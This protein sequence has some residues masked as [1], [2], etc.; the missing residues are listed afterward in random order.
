M[1]C[2]IWN[3]YKYMAINIFTF[4]RFVVNLIVKIIF[5]FVLF[6]LMLDLPSPLELKLRTAT[7][8][9]K[10]SYK[11][12]ITFIYFTLSLGNLIQKI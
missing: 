9:Y 6:F 7:I 4:V 3:F 8:C 11:K 5:F 1:C 12:K 2:G 10:T